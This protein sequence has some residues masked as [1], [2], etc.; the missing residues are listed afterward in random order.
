MINGQRYL[1][2]EKEKR[3][4]TRKGEKLDYGEY[5]E[6]KILKRG[7]IKA[8]RMKQVIIKRVHESQLKGAGNM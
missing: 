5:Q 1:F 4:G 7:K 3:R 8:E 2:E 6:N